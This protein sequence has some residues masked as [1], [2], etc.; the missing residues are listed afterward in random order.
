M[1]LYLFHVLTINA[2]QV[3]WGSLRLVSSTSNITRPAGCLESYLGRQ[4]GTV[5]STGFW[6]AAGLQPA[7]IQ[8]ILRLWSCW[9]FGVCSC[10][11]RCVLYTAVADH[12]NY[13]NNCNFLNVYKELLWNELYSMCPNSHFMCSYSPVSY[14]TTSSIPVFYLSCGVWCLRAPDPLTVPSKQ[15]EFVQSQSGCCPW[16]LITILNKYILILC[17]QLLL[18][19]TVSVM[20]AF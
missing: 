5:C 17:I 8:H 2:G 12:V 11:Y 19:H 13:A 20:G 1:N 4:W 7:G 9:K 18:T 14:P 6:A 15:W 10:F 16:V 3:P